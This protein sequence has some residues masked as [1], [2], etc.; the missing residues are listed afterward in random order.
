MRQQ[1]GGPMDQK[2]RA[3]SGSCAEQSGIFRG[4]GLP[5]VL[6]LPVTC[7]SVT[8][9]NRGQISPTVADYAAEVAMRVRIEHLLTSP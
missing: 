7:Q 5:M 2:G 3:M 8:G 4:L 1:H 6:D 9:L